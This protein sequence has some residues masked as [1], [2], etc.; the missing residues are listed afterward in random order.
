MQIPR[1]QWSR[2]PPPNYEPVYLTPEGVARL[3]ARLERLKHSL[4][5]VIAETSRTSA[6]GDR[7][8]NAEYKEAKGILRR[9]HGQIFNIEDQL[10][11]VVIIPSGADAMGTI[12]LGSTVIVEIKKDGALLRKTFRI[13]GSSE[14]DPG[15]GRISHTSPLGAALLGRA[16]GDVVTVQTPGGTQEYKVVKVR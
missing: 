5:D 3:K 7:S 14:T 12:Q 13:L 6:Y 4:P 10:K 15:R 16:A 11:R 2:R 9:T 1:R 8:D